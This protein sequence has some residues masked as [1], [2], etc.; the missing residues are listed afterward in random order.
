M[1]VLVNGVRLFFAWP[2]APKSFTC[3]TVTTAGARIPGLVNWVVEAGAAMQ[4]QQRGL[5]P[6]ARPV[7]H[8]ARSLNVIR[9]N[10]SDLAMAPGALAHQTLVSWFGALVECLL[11]LKPW[12]ESRELPTEIL[13][14]EARHGGPSSEAE[15]YL[16]KYCLQ[17]GPRIRRQL[18]SQF[19]AN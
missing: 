2:I 18:S 13:R 1:R 5:L 3:T 15:V 19:F 9:K 14:G 17:S 16:V 4:E 6:H 10:G 8:Q 12:P 11:T 7:R